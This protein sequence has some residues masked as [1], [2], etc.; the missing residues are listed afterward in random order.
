M[1]VNAAATL[2]GIT[3]LTAARRRRAAPAAGATGHDG[4]ASGLLAAHG[5]QLQP[6]PGRQ[7][8]LTAPHTSRL[9]VVVS[10]VDDPD[11]GRRLMSTR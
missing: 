7:H 1:A 4:A 3:A 6:A 11:E 5:R 8:R 9:P 2:A 10:V